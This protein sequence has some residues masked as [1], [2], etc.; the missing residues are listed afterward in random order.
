MFYSSVRTVGGLLSPLRRLRLGNK[1]PTKKSLGQGYADGVSF[2]PGFDP[3]SP[4]PEKSLH[5][6]PSHTLGEQRSYHRQFIFGPGETLQVKFK[7]ARQ[8]P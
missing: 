7:M 3:F 2:A 4:L 1:F 5:L 6:G 8:E